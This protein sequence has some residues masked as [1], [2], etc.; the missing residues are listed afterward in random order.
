[1][2]S[3][4]IIALALALLAGSTIETSARR[5][6]PR[7][8][9]AKTVATSK[10]KTTSSGIKVVADKN[11]ASRE[12]LP[13]WTTEA[14][15]VAWY[16]PQLK[17]AKGYRLAVDLPAD[18]T[19]VG[20]VTKAVVDTYVKNHIYVADLSTFN[21]PTTVAEIL[22]LQLATDL[23]GG[24]KA[25]VMPRKKTINPATDD[26]VSLDYKAI[27]DKGKYVTMRDERVDRAGGESDVIVTTFDLST[28]HELRATDIFKQ[29]DFQKVYNLMSA[30][31]SEAGIADFATTVLPDYL[32]NTGGEYSNWVNGPVVALTA[33]GIVVSVPSDQGGHR[34]VTLPYADVSRYLNSDLATA[35]GIDR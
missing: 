24:P 17:K 1:M 35:I 19:R 12:T 33:D 20:A 34:Q 8:H 18:S 27:Y 14:Y 31:A 9:A 3:K 13:G 16:Q 30:K 28:G 25:T 6:A 15:T 32:F 5:K 7:R 11:T 10:N 2:K 23:N 22:E 4:L 29:R 21:I 26:Y